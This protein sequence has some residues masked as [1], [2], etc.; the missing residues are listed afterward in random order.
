[1]ESIS[2]VVFTST[3]TQW[4]ASVLV[5]FLLCV[6]VRSIRRPFLYYWAWS[7]GCL[8]IALL[9]LSIAFRSDWQ[10]PW[11]FALYFGFEYAWAFLLLAGC[12]NLSRDVRLNKR[13]IPAAGVA[14]VLGL[15]LAQVDA[16]FNALFAIHAIMLTGL[17]G[18]SAYVLLSAQNRAEHGA[19][20]WL[21]GLALVLMSVVFGHYVLLCGYAGLQPEDITF[22]HLEYAPVY[23]MLLELLLAFGMV[24][25]GME[26]VRRQLEKAN[27]D[28]AAA[29]T[30]LKAMAQED[31]LTEAY[32]RHAFYSFTTHGAPEKP[33]FLKGCV[34]ILDLNDLKWIN[35]TLGHQ[36][37]DGA[38]RAVS[39]AIRSVIR[40]DDLLFRWGG[41][42][43]LILWPHIS[44]A[45]ARARLDKLNP[46]LA[47]VMLPGYSLPVRVS[48][49]YGVA[50]VEK[51]TSLEQAIHEAD[52]E[53]YSQKQRLKQTI[54]HDT[55]TDTPT[56]LT[57]A[58]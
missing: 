14:A 19:G 43:F 52:S 31:S 34:A 54:R 39:R 51:Y 32:N 50:T 11:L 16:R 42:E 24:M 48:V 6:V 44:E 30:Q 25:V 57:L 8:A 12:L 17:L 3:V 4:T 22:V 10:S 41:D 9:A 37:G 55:P 15:L 53:M 45:D 27:R 38:I 2:S 1:M 58:R 36:A 56:R 13:H 40:A 33:P 47:E 5:A 20:H 35:D 7:W 46:L 21:M 49:A 28:L 18:L 29:S 23:D 26:S